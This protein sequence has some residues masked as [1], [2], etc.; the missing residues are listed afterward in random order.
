[1][2]WKH[3]EWT[4]LLMILLCT[5]C[6]KYHTQPKT[7]SRPLF[8]LL[9]IIYTSFVFL[10]ASFF[11]WKNGTCVKTVHWFGGPF[12][13]RAFLDTLCNIWLHIHFTFTSRLT[14]C[15][16]FSFVVNSSL[17]CKRNHTYTGKATLIFKY[18]FIC[19]DR[20]VNIIYTN[21]TVVSANDVNIIPPTWR[22]LRKACIPHVQF[23]VVLPSHTRK[24]FILLNG[25][26]KQWAIWL[27]MD[28]DRISNR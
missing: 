9:Q 25:A 14:F 2:C 22:L 23:C 3:W 8:N 12:D 20:L 18:L 19:D 5:F 6:S 11:S 10:S 15:K 13:G 27:F 16:S 28:L 21:D 26:R 17:A 24:S 7:F 1:M 4:W